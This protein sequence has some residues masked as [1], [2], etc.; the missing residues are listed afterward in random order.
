[1]NVVG[2]SVTGP[3][4]H[5]EDCYYFKDL[6]DS[7]HFPYGISAF[8]MLS[9]G[10][11]GYQGGDIASRLAC[12]AAKHYM[13]S[14]IEVVNR[15]VIEL[16][17]EKALLEIIDNANQAI[18]AEMQKLD[19]QN[20]GATF[21]G[22]FVSPTKAWV[23]HLG[24]SR[25]YLIGRG[26]AKQL[27]ADHSVVGRMLA[28]GLITEAEAQIHPSRNVVERALG[29]N[30]S[31]EAQVVQVEFRRG[32]TLLLCSDGVSTVLDSDTLAS[33]T[34]SEKSLDE[35][36]QA[37]TLMALKNGTDD[38]AT[39][40]LA[41]QSWSAF[42]SRVPKISLKDR[43]FSG[44]ISR[45]RVTLLLGLLMILM[46]VGGIWLGQEY[47][48]SPDQV[49][50]A[51]EET[52]A[53]DEGSQLLNGGGG[54]AELAIETTPV[55]EHATRNDVASLQQWQILDASNASPLTLRYLSRES[56]EEVPV[57]LRFSG[58]TTITFR[59]DSGELLP[60]EEV[61]FIDENG[62]SRTYIKLSRSFW[63]RP[64]G[65][66]N[67]LILSAL[68]LSGQTSEWFYEEIEHRDVEDFYVRFTPGFLEQ[69]D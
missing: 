23:A 21:V 56:D 68:N 33:V 28:D 50:P 3:R 22:A 10:M 45:Q 46:I 30:G 67:S 42:K 4:D 19:N 18:L 37:L 24:D 25:A 60:G 34:G 2:S 58:N 32:E 27:T 15:D 39:V 29:F 35:S 6:S 31:G 1:M 49:Q 8:L 66:G 7:S 41:T 26:N 51:T 59:P 53:T 13:E 14:L 65:G 36:A 40:V 12:E 43:V 57:K 55:V 9:D 17:V 64:T 38:N 61:H 16:D 47:Q 69:I 44:A 11:G 54:R 48:A 20:M 63:Q 62:K 52:Q 5:N